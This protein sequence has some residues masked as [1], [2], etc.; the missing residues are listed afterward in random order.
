ML[1]LLS[2]FAL[3]SLELEQ[4][5]LNCAAANMKL[6][7][8]SDLHANREAVSAV[9]AHAESQGVDQ[10]AFLGDFVGYG[11]DPG[12]V[13]DIVRQHAA[14]GAYVVQGNHDAAAVHGGPLPTMREEAALL[15]QWTHTQLNA[16]QLSYLAALPLTQT[17]G[18]LLF[19]HANAYG[20]GQWDYIQSRMEAVR[21]LQATSQAFTFCGHMHEQMLYY[22]S[23]TGKAGQ[24][25]PT[26]EVMI[27]ML[28]TRRWLAIA[29]SC[30]QPR[31]GNPAACYAIFSSAAPELIFHRVPYDNIAAAKKI[32]DAGL[33]V[34]L[35]ER[36]LNGR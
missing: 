28:T 25:E 32:I 27:P 22:L 11:A 29:G 3:P 24:F 10:Y 8:I 30:G 7:L 23:G 9:L 1:G 34:S 13:V 12:W 2:P 6:A 20:P 21:S 35:A 14:R 33:P 31:D 36:L 26:P 5:P 15:A 4:G 17:Q 16:E 19:V 18:E